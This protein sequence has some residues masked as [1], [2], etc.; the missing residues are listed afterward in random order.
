MKFFK[1]FQKFALKWNVIDLAVW[2]VIWSS[3]NKIVS[4]LVDSIIMPVLGV[5]TAGKD[6][7][8][9]QINVADVVIPYGAF[10]QSVVDFL[11]I[12]FVL[13]ATIK[14]M[15]RLLDKE[16]K[17]KPELNIGENGKPTKSRILLEYEMD[18]VYVGRDLKNESNKVKEFDKFIDDLKKLLK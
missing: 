11:L 2:V 14:V 5:F 12:A 13:F 4:S 17:K 10:V 7:S 6:F 8:K 18:G 15:N 16:E 3:F 1:E 9:L